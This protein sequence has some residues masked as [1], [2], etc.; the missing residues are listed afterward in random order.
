MSLL[1]NRRKREG[2]VGRAIEGGLGVIDDV[3]GDAAHH[4]AETVSYTHLD[5][6][7]GIDQGLMFSFPVV[8]DGQGGY[9]IVQGLKWTEFAKGK[10]AL[11]QDELRE[12]RAV[13]SD[14]LR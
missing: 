3:D 7:Y 4:L 8:S 11:T 13:V 9:H 6:S 5:G 10:V 12:E 2:V 14:L 1:S